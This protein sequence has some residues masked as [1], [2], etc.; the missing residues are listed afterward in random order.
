MTQS[1]LEYGKISL[2]PLETEDLEL[3][4]QWENDSSV[5]QVSN[6]LTPF[7]RFILRQYIE[8]SHRDIYEAK[9]LRL[10]IQN[11]EREPV[12]AIDLFD[13]EPYHQRAGIG[14]LIYATEDR[15]KGYASDALQLMCCYAKEIL[16]I[17]QLYA[18][19]GANNPTS[20]G[21]FE[22]CGF[23]LS[24]TKKDWLKLPDGWIDEYFFQRIL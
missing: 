19:I 12:G 6:T 10:I 2:R 8:E 5:W 7:S 24:G 23:Q 11:K 17:H 16:G 18:N 14:I 22:K 21:L 9:Q 4:Y 1:T 13:F 15:Q 20:V 3:L